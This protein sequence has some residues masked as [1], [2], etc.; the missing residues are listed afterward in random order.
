MNKKINY[1]FGICLLLVAGSLP[2]EIVKRGAFDFG[3]GEI[4]LQVAEVDTENHTIVKSIYDNSAKVYLAEDASHHPEI[5]FSEEIQQKAVD[6]TRA[7]KEKAVELGATEFTGLATAAYRQA[8][9]GHKLIDRYVNEL[10]I[11]VQIISQLE[12]GKLGFLSVVAESK[13]NPAEV[14]SWDIGGGSFQITYLN[15]KDEV[16]VYMAP[17]GRV[18]TKNELIKG[19]KGK[20]PA[21]V[22]SPNPMTQKEWQASIKHLNEVLPQVPSD[23]I[24]KLKKSNTK[25][26][27]ISG[28]PGQLRELKQYHRA[29]VLPILK[30]R[31]NQSDEELA[32]THKTPTSAVSELALIYTVM[33][34]LDIPSVKYADTISGSTSAILVSNEYWKKPELAA[35][36]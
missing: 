21:E 7:L 22:E 25:L 14:V 16:Q 34:K 33:Q 4:K 8:V 27:G 29:D 11:P 28:H 12:E 30:Q 17:L 15:A 36:G 24:A 5:G 10:G 3:S 20:N 26:I 31:L 13:L 35:T 23:L 2:A 6:A 32:K 9:N 1:F 19:V 18:T